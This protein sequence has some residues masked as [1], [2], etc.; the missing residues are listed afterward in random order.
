[1]IAADAV[2]DQFAIALRPD[3]EQRRRLSLVQPPRK[4]NI[5]LVTVIEGAHWPPRRV[6]AGN[7]IAETQMIEVKP[8]RHWHGC[9]RLPVLCL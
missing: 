9:F 2:I 8:F 5:D 4:L 1:M 6:V 7:G 3:H